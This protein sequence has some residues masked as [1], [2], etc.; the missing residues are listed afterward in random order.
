LKV[1]EKL[2]IQKK[3]NSAPKIGEEEEERTVKKIMQF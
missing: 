3:I 1:E 2:S